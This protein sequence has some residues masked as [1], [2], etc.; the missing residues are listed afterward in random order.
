MGWG[1]E[2]ITS[3]LARRAQQ[4]D[5]RPV[6]VVDGRGRPRWSAVWNGNPRLAGP[7][8][9]GAV[10]TLASAPGRRPY[11]ARE[12]AARWVWREWVCPVGE[13]HLDAAERAA[14]ARGNGLVV[15][16]PQL[17]GR[18]S[19][20][21]DWGGTRWAAL[22]AALVRDGCEVAQLGPPGTP[23]LPGARL[24]PTADFRSACAVLAHARLAILPEGGLH[25]AAAALGTPAIVLFGGFISPRQTGYAHQLNLF[26]GGEA[27]GMRRHCAHCR[28]AM[29][30]IGVDEVHAQARAMLVAAPADWWV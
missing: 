2:I 10:Q 22:V 3:G 9:A 18:A 15:V 5:A 24:V 26:T 19:P 16:E 12:T 11:I 27:C 6:R 21:K 28:R 30:A 1:D 13:I 23:L 29:A 7:A 14:G 4:A 8:H 20:N 17:K 25:H